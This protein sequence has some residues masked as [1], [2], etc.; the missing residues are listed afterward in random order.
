MQITTLPVYSRLAEQ[1][2][3]PLDIKQR[4]PHGL[5]LSCHQLETYLALT[6]PNV[7]VVINTAMT[8]DGKSLAGLLPLLSNWTDHATLALYPTNELIQD[9]YRKA[10]HDL[11]DWGHESNRTATLYGA[12]LD[13][14]QAEA[15]TLTRPDTLLR[16]LKNHRLVLSNPDILHAILQFCYRQRGS[17]PTI[18]AGQIAQLFQQLTFD[19]FHIFDAAQVAAVLAG[20]LFLYEQKGVYPLKTLFLSA[21]PDGVLV[22]LLN[23]TGFGN[24]LRYISP[25]QEGWYVHGSPPDDTW[26]CIL[27]GSEI[28]IEDAKVEEWVKAHYDDILLHWFR[29]HGRAAKGAIIVN[30][31]VTALRLLAFLKPV[32]EAEGLTVAPNTGLDGRSTRKAS[33]DADVLIGTSTVDI[34]VDF[35]INLL[36]FESSSAAHFMQRLGRLG[37]HTSYQGRD[38]TTYQFKQFAAYALVPSFIHERLFDAC[39]GQQPLLKDGSVV[40]REDLTQSVK[41]VYPEPAQFKHYARLWGRFQA[42]KVYD[43][44]LDKSIKRTYENVRTQLR[45]RYYDLFSANVK[46][47]F[48]D[49]QSYRASNEE[50]LVR[51]AQSFRGSSPFECGVLKDTEQE[52]LT[53]SLFWL[54]RYAYLELI[55]K[56]TFCEAVRRMG[57]SDKPYRHNYQVAFF[58]WHDLRDEPEDVTITLLPTVSSWGSE[59]HHTAQVLPGIEVDCA[60][61]PWLNELNHTLRRQPCVGLLLPGLHPEQVRKKVYLPGHFPLHTYID[62]NEMTGTIAIGRQALLLDSVLRFRKRDLFDDLAIFS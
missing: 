32:F 3:I 8:G 53:Y 40:T 1:D 50:L 27:Q 38:G 16:E 28:T 31:V 11:P 33:Y 55:D 29:T 41:Q 57:K 59:R 21:T 36:I 14:L 26:R 34:G 24:R 62:Y 44:L 5:Q 25:Q 23:K 15:E 58:R 51:E 42:A 10:E 56:E 6:D 18:I 54:L 22:P 47:A 45:R 9:Q 35:S 60:G 48:D 2:T 13:E 46:T 12:R 49:W 52:P 37:R 61:H 30:S 4:L 39:N 17:E 20:L 7:D 43:A 19:E